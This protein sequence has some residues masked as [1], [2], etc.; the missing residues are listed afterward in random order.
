MADQI[1]CILAGYDDMTEARLGALQNRLYENGFTGT[2]TKNLLQHMT[3]AT[4]P[5]EA[6]VEQALCQKMRQAA[7][8]C[9]P[10]P[11]SFNH[12]GIFGG[13]KVLF[14]APDATQQLLRL[15]EYFGPS[16]GWTAHS[17]LLIDEPE[18]I[19]RAL[20]IVM[21]DF[22]AF[23]GRVESLHLFAFWP[24][25]RILSLPLGK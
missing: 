1:L 8:E 25:R 3:L 18:A 10:F 9:R 12:V 2:H 13:G 21:E 20:P 23:E 24:T 6:G 7:G 17:T 4:F 22:S 15:R 11:V 14:A 16:L 5:E 19:Y